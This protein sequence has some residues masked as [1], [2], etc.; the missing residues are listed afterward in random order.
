MEGRE[1][2][3]EDD[4]HRDRKNEGRPAICARLILELTSPLDLV[5]GR[6]LQRTVDLFLSQPDE[7]SQIRSPHIGL[8][9]HSPARVLSRDYFGGKNVFYLSHLIQP[10]QFPRWGAQHDVL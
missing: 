8:N 10:D 4:G 6:Q 5:T 3:G 9:G 1:Q 2:Q 7:A